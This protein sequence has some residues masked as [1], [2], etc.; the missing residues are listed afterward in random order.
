M[1]ITL[2]ISDELGKKAKHFAI[3]EGKSLSAIVEELLEERLR[4]GNISNY[5]KA[6]AK[7]WSVF[8]KGFAGSGERFVRDDMYDR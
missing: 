4:R 3:D 1:N 6:Q 2:R 7:A 5:E 8:E